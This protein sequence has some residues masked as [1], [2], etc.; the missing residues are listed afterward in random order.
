MFLQEKNNY[1]KIGYGRIS[2][3]KTLFLIVFMLAVMQIAEAESI[4]RIDFAAGFSADIHAR[5]EVV[6]YSFDL[7]IE[8]STFYNDSAFGVSLQ[9]EIG[10]PSF[11]SIGTSSSDFGKTFKN[12]VGLG[13]SP[14]ASFLI[15][16]A[17]ISI[18]PSANFHY[19]HFKDNSL[20]VES[21]FGIEART[22]IALALSSAVSLTFGADI[23]LDFFI[24]NFMDSDSTGFIS[25][26]VGIKPKIGLT[27]HRKGSLSIGR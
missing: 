14:A 3:K 13:I 5:S 18:G 23:G 9:Y 4:N 10:F 7:S 6:L 2:H 21:Y 16:S 20:V 24:V 1:M 12:A 26:K 22:S 17:T 19:M 25:P 8:D 27:L 15:K 11:Y